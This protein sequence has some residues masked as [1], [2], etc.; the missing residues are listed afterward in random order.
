MTIEQIK[1]LAEQ[2]GYK[3]VK[4]EG[5]SNRWQNCRTLKDF[6][7]CDDEESDSARWRAE[8]RYKRM[9]YNDTIDIY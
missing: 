1:E 8:Q 3:L 5:D 2:N 6:E 7:S 9:Y 4:R